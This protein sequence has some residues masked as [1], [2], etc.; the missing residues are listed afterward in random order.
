MASEVT[1][2]DGH[3]V[4]IGGLTRTD[5]TESIEKIP[6][7]GDLPVLEYLFSTRSKGAVTTTLF[8]FLRPV[9]LRDDQFRD[10]KLL[11]EQELASAGLPS[12]YPSSEPMLMH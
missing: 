11:S 7:L 4:I 3:T 6:I 9:I 5:L 1:V 2:P 8:V 10:L 12:P